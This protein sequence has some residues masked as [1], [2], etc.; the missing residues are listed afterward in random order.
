MEVRQA[1]AD[2]AE[3]RDRLA[4]VQR[5]GG[6][7]GWAAIASGVVAL[8]AG[9]V[10]ALLAPQPRTR[11]EQHAVPDD[12]AHVVLAAALAI[13][14]GAILIW[15]AQQSRRQSRHQIR[16]VGMSIFRR[17]PRAASSPR[18]SCGTECLA[19]LPGMWCATYALRTVRLA[20]ARSA[21][22]RLRRGRVR[23]RRDRC[24]CSCPV[25]SRSHGG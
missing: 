18:R 24:C 13:N 16:T 5:F 10:Q 1:I 25:R 22:R 12:L 4:T 15:R 11:E 9:V 19:L 20:R 17:S 14:Y 7:S 21:A 3:V 23:L 8:G 6:Y 2:I